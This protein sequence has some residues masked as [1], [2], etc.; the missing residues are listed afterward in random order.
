MGKNLRNKYG[1]K[2]HDSA[3]KSITDAI[4]TATKKAIQKTAEATGDLIGNKIADKMTSVS[5]KKPAKELLNDETKEEDTE[6]TTN[7]KRY[8]SP[9]EGQKIIE[10]LRLVP[11]KD[12][13]F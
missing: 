7:R 3:K 10:E 13:Y 1:Q 8:I 4:K 11:K 2:L 5:K 9:E 12:L 6:I